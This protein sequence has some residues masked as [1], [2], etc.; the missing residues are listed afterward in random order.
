MKKIKDLRIEEELC[1]K[2]D[3]EL[4]IPVR[5]EMKNAVGVSHSL[6]NRKEDFKDLISEKVRQ[7]KQLAIDNVRELQKSK[8]L[9][10]MSFNE[11]KNSVDWDEIQRCDYGIEILREVFDI[12]DEDL[13]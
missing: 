7:L 12:K 10:E 4:Y 6:G 5:D 9:S 1:E 11:T 13:L 2:L 8:M 3:S